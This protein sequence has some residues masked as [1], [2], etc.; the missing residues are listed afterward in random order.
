MRVHIMLSALS[1]SHMHLAADRVAHKVAFN[2]GPQD[3]EKD[4]GSSW[5]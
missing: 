1:E 3:V 4:E 5:L 2:G